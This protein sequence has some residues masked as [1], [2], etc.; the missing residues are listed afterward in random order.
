MRVDSIENK[1]TGCLA[2][3]EHCP[4]K[5]ISYTHD[6]EGFT[7]PEINYELCVSCGKCIRNCPAARVS[8]VEEDTRISAFFGSHNDASIVYSS[9]SGGAFSL[10]AE[11]VIKSDGVVYGAVYDQ[12]I[13]RIIY[14]NTDHS[15]LEQLR[16]SKYV[17]SDISNIFVSVIQNLN[18]GRK[19]LFCGLPCHVDG[20]LSVVGEND[21]LITVDFICGGVA[22]PLFFQ[23]HLK[24][25][26]K[27]YNSQVETVDF[28]AKLY[29]WREYSIKIQF[30]N[31]KAYKN[32]AECDS[33]FKGY[34]Q[35]TYQRK[36]CYNCKYRLKHYSDIIIADYWGGLQRGL[37]SEKGLSMV[38]TNSNKGERFFRSLIENSESGFMEMPV[39][40]SDYAFKL[41]T[42]RYN[43]A[44][45]KR[46]EFYEKYKS[47]GFEKTARAFYMND[48]RTKKVIRS[49]SFFKQKIWRLF[50]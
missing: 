38:I 2:C 3:I 43:K 5:A 16:K 49:L 40:N 19:V 48:L 34:F 28:R 13:K 50:K 21:H 17:S 35:K 4:V 41:E 44:F 32:Y 31:G 47:D 20:L 9:S 25:L 27:R 10:M 37:K 14:S 8:N 36:S 22:S 24:K 15:T 45:V 29:G 1:C 46:Q 26:E 42:E 30:K 39:E 7:Y 33:F 18:A 23:E 6:E 11:S 12:S